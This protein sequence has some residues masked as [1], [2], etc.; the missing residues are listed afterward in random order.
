MLYITSLEL[1]C[2]ITGS[3]YLLMAFLHLPIPTSAHFFTF[4]PTPCPPLATLV[5]SLT[6]F[7]CCYMCS[8]VLFTFPH[9]VKSHALWLWHILLSPCLEFVDEYN[10]PFF[11]FIVT[12]PQWPGKKQIDS[13]L[14]KTFSL[15]TDLCVSEVQQRQWASAAQRNWKDYKGLY[16]TWS[17]ESTEHQLAATCQ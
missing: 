11:L 17:K 4:S 15:T 3:W 16:R 10:C 13:E 12:L 8:F 5:C 9:I 14:F 7:P 6:L 1:I 2:L